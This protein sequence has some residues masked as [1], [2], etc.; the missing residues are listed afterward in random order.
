MF[1]KSALVVAALILVELAVYLLA[2]ARF[3]PL[4]ISLL[5]LA[6]SM[7]GLWFLIKQ[8]PGLV[9]RT[10][11]EM[12]D[13][14]NAQMAE[15]LGLSGLDHT[16][17]GAGPDEATV[18]DRTVKVVGAGL[19]AFPGLL[20]GAV[21]LLLFV[22]P[23][24]GVVASSLGSRLASLIPAGALGGRS[25]DVRSARQDVV[26]VTATVKDPA[27]PSWSAHRQGQTPS[28]ELPPTPG[29]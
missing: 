15:R 14:F 19:L 3:G 10:L 17:G 5:V 8:A 9:A 20:T 7:V 27:P 11:R 13:G 26:D 2:A 16:V 25:F 6:L 12:A 24:R 21:G 4:A 22:G 28:R 23:V 1:V 18:A 29:T